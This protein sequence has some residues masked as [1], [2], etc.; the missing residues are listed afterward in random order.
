ML[1]F[2]ILHQAELALNHLRILT[3]SCFVVLLSIDST[4]SSGRRLT[5]VLAQFLPTGGWVRSASRELAI[6][7]TSMSRVG[8]TQSSSFNTC[9]KITRSSLLVS[10]IELTLQSRRCHRAATARWVATATSKMFNSFNRK[11]AEHA[12]ENV[13]AGDRYG[14]DAGLMQGQ[15]RMHIRIFHIQRKGPHVWNGN[16]ERELQQLGIPS[17]RVLGF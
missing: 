11:L 15:F 3:E 2:G 13:N 9:W 6:S 8:C 10:F 16:V 5:N 7:P 14:N 12:H 1:G 17:V 4:V